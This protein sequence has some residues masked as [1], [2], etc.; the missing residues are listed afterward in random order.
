MLALRFLA[1]VRAGAQTCAQDRTTYHSWRRCANVA[2]KA[3]SRPQKGPR[4][5]KHVRRALCQRRAAPSWRIVS[6]RPDILARMV[7]GVKSARQELSRLHL[8]R[9]HVAFVRRR[10]GL[11]CW[12]QLRAP[13]ALHLH[14]ARDKC[15]CATLAILKTGI[16]AEHVI[17]APT[18]ILLVMAGAAAALLTQGH[19]SKVWHFRHPI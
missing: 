14:S 16:V 15:V 1:R 9:R 4:V 12:V 17:L 2:H 13:A 18:R 3:S 6:A 8:G 11:W 10:A 5:A 19:T 7:G